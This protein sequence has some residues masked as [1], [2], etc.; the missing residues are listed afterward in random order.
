MANHG[1]LMFIAVSVTVSGAVF[2]MPN[3]EP[4]LD[5]GERTLA[6]PWEEPFAQGAK[7]SGIVGL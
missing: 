2:P 5:E 6:R 7:C 3:L 4:S 1:S